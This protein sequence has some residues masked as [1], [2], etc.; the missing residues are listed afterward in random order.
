MSKTRT[1]TLTETRHKQ[2]QRAL[3]LGLTMALF[4][5]PAMA[6]NTAAPD[7]IDEIIVTAMRRAQNLQSVPLSI[8]AFTEAQ[9]T[10]FRAKGLE[11]LGDHTANMYM[12]ASTEAGQSFITLRGI[13]AGITRSSGRAVG[14]YIDGV[15]VNT[16]TAMDVS[17]N[18]IAR[19]EVLKGPQG[20]LFGRDT[21][22]GA[23][24]ITTQKPGPDFGAQ[25]Q[26][27]LGSDGLRQVTGHTDL[28]LISDI[29]VLRLNALSRKTSG[30]IHNAFSGR[31]AGA[32]DHTAIGAQLY[33]TPT[34]RFDAHL[35]F[36]LQ[37]RDDRPNTMGEAITNIGADTIPYTINLDQ[38]EFQTQN[39]K[40]A[41]LNANYTFE[42]GHQLS[43]TSGW[44]HTDD[45]YIQD[46]DRLPQSIT[47]AQFDGVSRE[48]SQE[49]RLT[50]PQNT[51]YD[52]LIG[53]YYLRARRG[54]NPTF[55]VMG[56]AFLEQVL[57]IPAQFHPADEL[58]GQRVTTITRNAALF[59][60]ANFHINERLTLY[61]GARYSQDK[62][63]VDY[64]SFG[65]VFE[66]FG[67][68]PL[69]ARTAVRH[70]PLSWMIGVRRQF[71][72]QVMGYTSVSRGYRSAAIKDDFVSAADIAA[73][74][75]FFTRPEFLTNYETGLKSTWF[76]QKLRINASAFMMD[77]TD[78]QV[79]VSKPPFLF[80]RSLTNAAKA[81]ISGFEADLLARIT[82]SL[83]LSTSL[84]Y[85]RSRYDDFVPAPGLDLSGT[86]FGDAP[87]WTFSSALDYRRPTPH[88]G[89]LT[90]HLDYTNR[91]AP[92][93]AP[94]GGSAFVGDYGI[95]N[96]AL[97]YVAVDEHWQVKFWLTNIGNVQRPAVT[98][99]WGAGLGP[100][101]ENQTV[102]YEPPRRF[103]ITLTAKL[104]P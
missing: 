43:W 61:G 10:A 70:R 46:G 90:A 94:L 52:Y 56:S 82:P 50:S 77:Y 5:A 68:P 3:A 102:R 66:I 16:D 39:A 13:N 59:G 104:G 12:P 89:A 76:D 34:D 20:T 47:V 14:V 81:H 26:M 51:R 40:R 19:V 33:F 36:N 95:W 57:G 98:K 93:N 63:N 103:G 4:G 100:L 97:G 75:G 87:V 79:S 23:I 30:Y 28:P 65:E 49:I 71:T 1:K 42:T 72:P 25:L 7:Q 45:F 101:I 31:K 24:N 27:T 78:I 55:P 2:H 67:L 99:L 80:L 6:Q 35:V 41:S 83:H 69:Q 29:A 88:G 74:S 84:G 17:M 11:D 73:G 60:H 48:L 64:N 91:T 85:V 15:Y 22:G 21:I 54:F 62:K 32:E 9:I 18:D 8:T 53:G 44:S 96:G 37:K 58:D 86:S 92:A 38:D